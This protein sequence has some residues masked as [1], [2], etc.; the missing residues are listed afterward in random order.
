MLYVQVVA[1]ECLLQQRSQH[2]VIPLSVLS[3]VVQLAIPLCILVLFLSFFTYR[4]FWRFLQ[5]RQDPRSFLSKQLK[6]SAY[7]VLGFFYTSLTQASL[8]TFSCYQIDTPVP[9]EIP[10][11]DNLQ[12]SSC[13]HCSCCTIC[14]GTEASACSC[15]SLASA[16]AVLMH[17]WN[18][19]L[20]QFVSNELLEQSTL[21]NCNYDA[22]MH[23]QYMMSR[24]QL[25]S[26]Q[27]YKRG[28]TQFAISVAV[29]ARH[30]TLQAS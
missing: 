28:L 13:I 17:P 25:Q 15:M 16:Q 21:G 20:L 3:S 7:A 1:L 26:L 12:A 9:S 29:T 4:F 6:V 27:L 19:T 24:I 18:I 10:Y 22:E 8:D 5:G 2:A 30:P 23:H 11:P 14:I